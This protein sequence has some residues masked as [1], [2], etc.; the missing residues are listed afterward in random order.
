MCFRKALTWLLVWMLLINPAAQPA[1][2]G[3]EFLQTIFKRKRPPSGVDPSVEMLAAEIDWLEKHIDNY[4][5]VVPKQPDVWGQARLTKHRQEFEKVMFNEL[6]NFNLLVNGTISRSDSAFLANA[7]A[8]SAAVGGGAPPTG[9]AITSVSELAGKGNP[10]TITKKSS[11]ASLRFNK[12]ARSPWS[13]PSP[14]TSEPV[15]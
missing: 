10:V 2:Q 14:W 12:R 8:L 9:T 1:L 4:G 3:K 7:F 5:T 11:R 6:G 13:R 15:I